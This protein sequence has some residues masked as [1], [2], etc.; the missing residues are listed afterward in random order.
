MWLAAYFSVL[1][2]ASGS[3]LAAKCRAITSINCRVSLKL[4]SCPV[5][6]SS[7]PVDKSSCPIDKFVID[8]VSLGNSHIFAPGLFFMN[9]FSLSSLS[10]DSLDI[11]PRLMGSICSAFMR[12]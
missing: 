5:D 8:S 10:S 2:F 12:E 1:Y 7:R 3:W 4:S 9:S 6:L 11:S